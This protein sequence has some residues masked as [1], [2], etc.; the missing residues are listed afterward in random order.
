MIRIKL[1]LKYQ[2]F[3]VFVFLMMIGLIFGK[4]LFFL[5][6]SQFFYGVYEVDCYFF[7]LIYYVCYV[8]VYIQDQSYILFY[9]L[10][11]VYGFVQFLQ[12]FLDYVCG[13][14]LDFDLNYVFDLDFDFWVVIV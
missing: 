5:N 14:I 6:D 11:Y 1:N 3:L 4:E 9:V 12:C 7:Y 13:F 10:C 2:E 8:Y